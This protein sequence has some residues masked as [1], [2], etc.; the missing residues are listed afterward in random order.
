METQTNDVFAYIK[1]EEASFRTT[2]VPLTDSKD[3][4]MYEHVQ[5]CTSV[6]NAWFFQGSNDINSGRPYTD[7]VTPIINVAFRTEGFDVK[8]IVP[9]VNDSQKYYKSFL[10]KKFHPKWAR[11]NEIDTLIDKAVEMSV[12]YDL[13]LFKNVN[14]L[15][16]VPLQSIAFCDQ[17]D[18]MAGPIC[19]KHQYSVSDLL[20]FKGKWD[21]DNIDLAILS[22]KN[23]KPVTNATDKEVKTPGKYV[24]V[25]EL[26]GQ[27]PESWVKD[28]GDPN[29]YTNQLHIITYYVGSDGNKNGLTLFRGKDKKLSEIFDALKID[30]VRSYGRACGRSLVETL[31]EPQV[32]TNYSSIKIKNML[33]SALTLFQTDSD[34]IAGQKLTDLKANTILKHE[35]GRPI[36]QVAG[37]LINLPAFTNHQIKQENDARVLGSASDAQLG[38]NPVSGTPFAL[39]SLVVQQG[40]GIH[41]YRQGKIATF[42]SD[43]LY[44]NWILKLLV[45]EMNKGNEWLDELSL[46]ELQYISDAVSTK[47][48]NQEAIRL[49]I[50]MGE[51]VSQGRKPQDITQEDLVAYR[52]MVKEQWLKGGNKRFLKIVKDELKDLPMDV[53]I[54]IKQKQKDMTKNVENLTN[55]V[56]AVLQNPQAFSQIPGLGKAF[57]EILENSGFSPVD[58]NAITTPSK[59]LTP[60]VPQPAAAAQ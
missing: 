43:R 19:I 49:V 58:F 24:E 4:N 27:L 5:R 42:F 55:I 45:A 34:E 30:Q 16:V 18:V 38:T 14:K 2:R 50:K 54:N 57:N 25:Y 44:K 36:T 1:A 29:K 17:T 60:P 23:A 56:R 32:W 22:A 21:D 48:A 35:Q 51:D 20:D 37:Q 28:D 41:E 40:Q 11:N 6:A 46:E 31:F 33:D 53:M 39:Q 52:D 15:E 12:I 8:D 3:W 59:Q 9:Y 26:H 13:V 7:I 47:E 10:V